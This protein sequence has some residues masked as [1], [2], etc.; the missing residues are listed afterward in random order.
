MP[1]QPYG[2][3]T[4]PLREQRYYVPDSE[5][6][7]PPDFAFVA[8]VGPLFLG[9]PNASE[10]QQGNIGDCYLLAALLALTDHSRGPGFI[11]RMLVDLRNGR[12]LVRLFDEYLHPIF[13]ELDKTIMQHQAAESLRNSIPFLDNSS[14]HNCHKAPWVYLIEKA[15]AVHQLKFGGKCYQPMKWNPYHRPNNRTYWLYENDGDPRAP[16]DQVEALTSGYSSDSFKILLGRKA[17]LLEIPKDTFQ[18]SPFL[19]AIRT[20]FSD[21]RRPYR[22]L[23]EIEKRDFSIVFSYA[24]LNLPLA[25][26]ERKVE[27][28]IQDFRNNITSDSTMYF[29]QQFGYTEVPRLEAFVSYLKLYFGTIDSDTKAALL[30]F[31][32]EN[33]ASK[34]GLTRYLPRYIGIYETI[35]QALRHRHLVCL[36]SDNNIGRVD[37]NPLARRESKIK[38]LAGPHAYQVINSYERGG[39]KILL[40]RNPWHVYT[41]SYV[42][43]PWRY[44]PTDAELT[45]NPQFATAAAN[46]PEYPALQAYAVPDGPFQPVH[47]GELNTNLAIPMTPAYL[48]R[49]R[50]G[51][52][53][54][55]ELVLEDVIKRFSRLY[56]CNPEPWLW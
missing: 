15:Y 6:K 4:E 28:A 49:L 21:H 48:E 11:N 22:E 16:L 37:K 23:H 29:S 45:A 43:H 10:I 19:T 42:Y 56:V 1:Y 18:A 53:G 34:R 17:E 55:F 25:E 31:F 50:L 3:L 54:V 2:R 33:L 47:A 30:R 12:V 41:R 24:G 7:A 9:E 36:G 40:I 46:E 51:N 20:V 52:H 39:L 8:I 27:E 44:T 38:G 5:I 13:Y 14:P 26:A 35:H 32:N